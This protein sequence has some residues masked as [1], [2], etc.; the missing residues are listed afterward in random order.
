MFEIIKFSNR[1]DAI[2]VDSVWFDHLNQW[3]WCANDDGYAVRVGAGDK[4]IFMHRYIIG[5]VESSQ[6]VDHINGDK[7][8]NRRDNLRIVSKKDNCKWRHHNVR[9]SSKFW[10]V[11]TVNESKHRGYLPKWVTD[12]GGSRHVGYFATAEAAF[13]A[14]KTAMMFN[15]P[16]EWD[17]IQRQIDRTEAQN[18]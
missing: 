16:E 2:F 14:V 18:G 3:S 1:D 6:I 9:S 17:R 4:K 8:D 13:E 12:H 5:A 10:G 11:N 7:R 15:F